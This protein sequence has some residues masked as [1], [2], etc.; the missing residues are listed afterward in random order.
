MLFCFEDLF[1]FVLE[2]RLLCG[3][4]DLF[5]DNAFCSKKMHL[6]KAKLFFKVCVFCFFCKTTPDI[7]VKNVRF[8]GQTL[9]ISYFETPK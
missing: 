2:M 4:C 6:F 8:F 7:M 3:K 9:N 1:F 5:E